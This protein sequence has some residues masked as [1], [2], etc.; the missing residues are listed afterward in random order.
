MFWHLERYWLWSSKSNPAT[1]CFIVLVEMQQYLDAGSHGSSRLL[2]FSIVTVPTF[3][4]IRNLAAGNK[5]KLL[6]SFTEML[7][8]L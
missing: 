1:Q 5:D 3:F 4:W 6:L 2:S 8:L 7:S